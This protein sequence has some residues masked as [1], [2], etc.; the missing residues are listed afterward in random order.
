MREPPVIPSMHEQVELPGIEELPPFQDLEAVTEQPLPEEQMLIKIPLE[1]PSPRRL[2]QEV[3]PLPKETTPARL[4]PKIPRRPEKALP[5]LPE[6]TPVHDTRGAPRPRR[7]RR[8]DINEFELE[9]AV[10]TRK[11]P[12]RRLLIHDEETVISA[13]EFKNNIVTSY[14]QL[15]PLTYPSLQKS[16]DMLFREPGS[17]IGSSKIREFW[18]NLRT[19]PEPLDPVWSYTIE[20]STPETEEPTPV[21]EVAPPRP[22]LPVRS[23]QFF[24]PLSLKS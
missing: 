7:K 23:V 17:R 4:S 14:K 15:Q 9:P 18:K 8:E 5:L 16:V 22:V 21:S 11:R 19:F 20:E 13:K 1:S 2:L 3:T 24:D 12:R 10:Q 6:E